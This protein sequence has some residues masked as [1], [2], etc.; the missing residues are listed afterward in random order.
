MCRYHTNMV[1]IKVNFLNKGM[2]LLTSAGFFN[3]K[4]ADMAIGVLGN[5][6]NKK[7]AIVTTAAGGKETNVYS[8]LAKEQLDKMG[9]Q[10]VDFVDL[11]VQGADHFS[12]YDVIYVCGG[13]TFKLLKF[14]RETDFKSAILKV[15]NRGGLYIGVS[16]GSLIVGPS[17]QI[18]NEIS[19]DRNDVGVSDFT[20][21]G[22][23]DKILFPH[24]ESKYEMEIKNFELKNNVTVTR[25]TNNQAVMIIGQEANLIE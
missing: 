17:V 1:E 22:I 18:A 11:E 12:G 15:L 21:M 4:V 20:G 23:V 13:N 9:F 8:K 14:A 24:Y 19:A 25:L 2:L 5:T 7:V 10:D 3:P 16:A 6:I